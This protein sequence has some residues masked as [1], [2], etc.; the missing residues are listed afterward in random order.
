MIGLAVQTA[1][2][3]MIP[4]GIG[5][6]LWERL[7]PVERFYLTM[8]ETEADRTGANPG[9]KLDDYHNFAKALRAEGWEDLMADNTPNRARLK[10]AAEFRR[11]LMSG[12]PFAGGVVR[13]T[14]YAV[15]ELRLAAAREEDP[16]A[17]ADRVLHGLRD[18]FGE[19][20]RQR[21]A[22]REVAAWLGQMWGRNRPGEGS[23]AR[24][25]AGI[26]QA[27]RL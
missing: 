12:H 16:K 24:V 1:T 25:L 11:A 6:G 14:L 23:A 8:A 19:W 21:G 15:N 18:H 27:E 2:E 22:V 26:I 4:E 20:L 13:P 5:E 10:G 9:G 17:A 7:A 3:F